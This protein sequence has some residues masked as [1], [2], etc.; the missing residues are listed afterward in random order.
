MSDSTLLEAARKLRPVIEADA[1]LVEE[2]LGMTPPIVKGF[3]EADLFRLLLP[4]GLG[5]HEADIPTIFDVC[6]EIAYADGSVGWTYAQNTAV[7]G[8]LAYL[9]PEYAKPFADLRAGAG[10]FA[11][12]GVAHKEGNQFRV[13]GNYTFGTGC[14]H[15]E[16]MGGAG[17]EMHDGEIGPLVDG[18]PILRAYILPMNQVEIK[19]NWDVM[20]LAGTGSFDYEVPEQMV[21]AGATFNAFTLEPKT[22]GALYGIGAI[23]LGTV[24][25]VAWAF[26]VAER[27]LAEIVEIVTTHGRA[28]MGALPLKEQQP[29]QERLGIHSQAVNSARLLAREVY[30]STVDAIERGESKPEVVA[31]LRQTKAAASYCLKICTEAV[32]FA[33]E[34]SGSHGLRNPSRLQRCFRDMYVGASHLVFDDRNYVESVKVRLGIEPLPF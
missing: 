7:H 33:Y 32:T 20:G 16:F 27:A 34:A 29:F 4:K 30:G 12:N 19:G 22:G 10:M 14:S 25:S 5:G 6:E 13:S 11:P 28:R 3:V 2:T 1:N 17:L 24:G 18:L 15:A 26:G 21:D 9:E 31:R 8:Y 23:P